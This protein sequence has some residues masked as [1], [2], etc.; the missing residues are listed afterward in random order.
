MTFRWV[1]K[2]MVRQTIRE[3]ASWVALGFQEM[4]LLRSECLESSILPFPQRGPSIA[5]PLDLPAV[6]KTVIY[7]QIIFESPLQITE[8][9]RKLFAQ[10]L[11]PPLQ[12]CTG[13]DSPYAKWQR[14]SMGWTY[15][16]W[17]ESTG[18]VGE[19]D[20]CRPWSGSTVCHDHMRG[21]RPQHMCQLCGISSSGTDNGKNFRAN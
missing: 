9:M 6:Y 17:Q 10:E 5:S 1:L 8:D 18:C 16:D 21:K 19:E 4:C 7:S 20:V 2:K 15:C 14:S 11:E 3:Q 12:T 13:I